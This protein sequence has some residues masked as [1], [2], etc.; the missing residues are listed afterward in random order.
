ME[1]GASSVMINGVLQ[2]QMSSAN[3]WDL[4]GEFTID[5]LF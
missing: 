4:Q 5:L 3:S 2:M 1:D